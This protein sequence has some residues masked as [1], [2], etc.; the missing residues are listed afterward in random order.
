MHK[1]LPAL[2]AALFVI[3]LLPACAPTAPATAITPPTPALTAPQLNTLY[4][5]TTAEGK[6]AV[7]LTNPEIQQ[8]N[9]GA[10]DMGVLTFSDG[11]QTQP[12]N[13]KDL[14]NPQPFYAQGAEILEVTNFAFDP[15]RVHFYFSV[16]LSNGAGP[17]GKTLQTS[18]YKLTSQAPG[19]WQIWVNDIVGGMP[20]YGDHQGN[21][22]IDQAQGDYLVVRVMPC[23]AC[24]GST[25]PGLVLVLNANT[26]A[27]KVLNLAGNVTINLE[28]KTVSYQTLAPVQVA[29]QPG[30]GC[31]EDGSMTG[32]EPAGEVL[33]EALP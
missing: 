17:E 10:T 5:G 3:C 24:G 4:L 11:Q 28:Q 27:E 25:V 15:E 7:F 18:V 16:V 8:A 2:L 31:G 23:Y 9:A 29:C 12:F 20:K 14:K 22:Y 13:F 30:P 6:E 32:Y 21:T 33:V 1:H 26:R 19:N